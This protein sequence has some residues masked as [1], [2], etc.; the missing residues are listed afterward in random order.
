M[1]LDSL[2]VLVQ[3]IAANEDE[4]VLDGNLGHDIFDRFGSLIINFRD[5][6]VLLR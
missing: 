5:M 1:A 6:A 3:S 2:D 4:N